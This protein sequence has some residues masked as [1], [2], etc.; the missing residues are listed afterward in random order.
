MRFAEHGLYSRAEMP[1]LRRFGLFGWL[2]SSR[3]PLDSR[4]DCKSS[5]CGASD[6]PVS[7]LHRYAT[8]IAV[9]ASE[10]PCCCSPLVSVGITRFGYIVEAVC[11]AD[12]AMYAWQSTLVNVAPSP[13]R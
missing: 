12:A 8:S 13:E 1:S 3:L 9:S 2:S 7:S 4:K 5:E 11:P 10:R 6:G